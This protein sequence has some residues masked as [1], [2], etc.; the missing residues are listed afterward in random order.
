MNNEK[1]ITDNLKL[2]H[3]V[4]NRLFPSYRGDEDI[5]EEGMLGLVKAAN[6]FTEDSSVAFST[7]AFCLIRNE[8]INYLRRERRH[9]DVISLDE[10]IGDDGEGNA[11]T[12][13]DTLA[14]EDTIEC[15]ENPEY[16]DHVFTSL[17]E[18]EKV[19]VMLKLR[20][21]SAEETA[22][23]VNTSASNVWRVLR[24]V[25][26]KISNAMEKEYEVFDV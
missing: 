13:G 25:R 16:F 21:Y 2:V 7:Y 17:K 15:V 3:T 19:I 11:V 24:K 10:P 22:K 18:K 6:A 1:L 8:I 5:V 12:L 23:K 20:G 26:D 9:T 14:S 4:I